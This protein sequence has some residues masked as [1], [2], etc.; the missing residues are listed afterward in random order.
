MALVIFSILVVITLCILCY[1]GCVP[2]GGCAG[3]S[4]G[5]RTCG[6][7]VSG[8]G[9]NVSSRASV[10][11]GTGG[12]V[13]AGPGCGDGCCGANCPG[14]RCKI[15]ASM[16]TFTLGSTKCS[17]VMLM[18]RSV[19]GGGRL[20]SVSTISGGVSFEEIGGLGMC[21]SGGTV[22]LAASVG[23]VRR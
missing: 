20:C 12:C 13:G 17:L 3:T 19:G 6:D 23:R 8:S 16:M 14:S 11:G 7:G 15:Y 9:S 21:F 5:V 22:D 4:F 1:F 18:G 10:L 2:R